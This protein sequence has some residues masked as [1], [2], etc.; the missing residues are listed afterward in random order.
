[1]EAV[2]GKIFQVVLLKN[3]AIS[4]NKQKMETSSKSR[5]KT[6]ASNRHSSS[7]CKGT[8]YDFSLVKLVLKIH[9][10]LMKDWIYF[11]AYARQHF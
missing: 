9:S 3:F 4:N 7:Q 2:K 10:T 8:I 11:C 1:M 5:S 6:V